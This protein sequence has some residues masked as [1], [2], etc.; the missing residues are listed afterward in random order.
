ML[1][2]YDLMHIT[3]FLHLSELRQMKRILIVEDSQDLQELLEVQLK[4]RFEVASTGTLMLARHSLAE[5]D[6]DLILLDVTLPDGSGFDFCTSLKSDPRYSGIP[7]I[8]LTGKD[9]PIEK[10]LAFSLGAD[11]YIVKPFEPSEL[12]A[13]IAA[14][15]RARPSGASFGQMR[16]DSA[17]HAG[18]LRFDLIRQRVLIRRG[19]ADADAQL[20]PFEF[21]I[22]HFLATKGGSY[23]TPNS[24]LKA[25]SDPSVHVTYGNIYTHI[26]AIRKKL[27]PHSCYIES[28]P[29]VGYRFHT[30][31][32]C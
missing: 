18:D 28:M 9:E 5:R 31:I 22:L 20:T 3:G 19:G 10:V 15:L 16:D 26:S 32:N 8:F 23:F 1:K 17:L 11:D 30:G 6:F 12:M 13:R 25:V 7:I 24:L 27:G 4:A 21:K 14:R 29:R 2:N